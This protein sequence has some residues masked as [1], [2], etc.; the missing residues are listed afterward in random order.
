MSP[1]LPPRPLPPTGRS[2]R[3]SRPP[4]RGSSAKMSSNSSRPPALQ[5]ADVRPLAVAVLELG[6]GLGLV[7][8]VVAR[9]LLLGEAEVDERAVPGVAER[10]GA[11]FRA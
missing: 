5:P 6:L 4:P 1:P 7:V 2:T 9:I 8:G 10:H 3:V 11:V